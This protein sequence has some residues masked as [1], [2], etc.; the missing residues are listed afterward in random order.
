MW[1]LWCESKQKEHMG[2]VYKD[3]NIA[4][5]DQN[6]KQSTLSIWEETSVQERELFQTSR[7]G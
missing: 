2:K 6:L 4:I 3:F 5:K 1:N 7:G